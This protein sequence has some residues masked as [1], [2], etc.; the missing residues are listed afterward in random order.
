MNISDELLEQLRNDLVL[1]RIGSGIKRLESHRQIFDVLNPRQ[2]NSVA[3]VGYLAQWVDIGFGRATL[4]KDLVSRFSKAD[5]A[6]LNLT[7]YVHLRMAEGLVAMSEE[8]FEQAIC[9]FSVVLLLEEEI[10][11]KELVAI[12][13]FWTGRCHRRAGQYQDALKLVT[14]GSRLASELNYSKMSAVM[15]VLEAWI[16]FQEEKPNEA[17]R[18]LEESEAT[19][20]DSDDY[21]TLGNI[22]SAYGRIARRQARFQQALTHFARAIE[23]YRQRNPQ[24]HN[25]ARSLVNIA[26]VERLLALQLRARIDNRAAR[27][28]SARVK[29]RDIAVG[30]MQERNTFQ[31]FHAEAFAHLKDALNIYT[32]SGDRRGLGGVHI[33]HGYLYLDGGELDRASSEAAAAFQ[34]GSDKKDYILQARARILQSAVCS[35]QFD[36]QLETSGRDHPA[37]AANDYAREAV[38]YAKHTQSR[39]LLAKAYIA[40]GLT[41]AGDFFD[42]PITAQH[43]CDR[44]ASVLNSENQDY[45]WRELQTLRKKLLG[46]AKM[47]STLR[48]WSQGVV[49]NKSFR[50]ISEEF[51]EMIIP[52]VWKR[53]GHKISRV[54]SRLSISPKKVRRVLRKTGIVDGSKRNS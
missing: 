28:R 44:A 23:L 43:C 1:R 17:L 49:G 26:Y 51:A 32:Q 36:E 45:V 39:R 4:I 35:A 12:T 7:D 10:P 42:D 54:V 19:L 31:N 18:I 5:R 48:E 24:H 9:H 52:S 30:R 40:L 38:E 16:A 8:N 29:P 46:T 27:K 14:R 41:L 13:S 3:M 21:V 33:T 34:L 2:K 11:N 50:Q 47:D 25:V 6:M 20:S 37:Q 22:Q 15:R 53:E